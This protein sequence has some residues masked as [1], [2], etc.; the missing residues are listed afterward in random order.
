V[1]FGLPLDYYT[2]YPARVSAVTAADVKAAAEK[3]LRDSG[4]QVLVVGDGS[5][6]RKDL[7]ALAAEGIF[8]KGGLV[9]LDADGEPSKPSKP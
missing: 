4:L 5:V 7:E 2:A 8:G 9:V 3:H 1:F 6:F